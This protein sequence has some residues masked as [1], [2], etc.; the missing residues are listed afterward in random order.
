MRRHRRRGRFTVA[1]AADDGCCHG[2]AAGAAADHHWRERSSSRVW[3]GGTPRGAGTASQVREYLCAVGH[4]LMRCPRV[5]WS[6]DS[7]AQCTHALTA[8]AIGVGRRPGYPTDLCALSQP[9][10]PSRASPR[11]PPRANDAA[12][13]AHGRASASARGRTGG[14]RGTPFASC[15]TVRAAAAVRT[16]LPPPPPPFRGGR[17]GGRRHHGCRHWPVAGAAAGHR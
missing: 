5:V 2:P 10:R 7:H 6:A 3:Q 17:V 12:F 4:F 13:P 15:A 1:V 9:A 11:T 8:T 14:G 16:V